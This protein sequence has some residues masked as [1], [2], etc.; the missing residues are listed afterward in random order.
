METKLIF[1]G[2]HSF[3]SKNNNECFVLDFITEPKSTNDKTRAYVVDIAIFT[4]KEKYIDFINKN[5]LLTLCPVHCEICGD[6]AKYS[7]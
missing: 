2:Y 3:T 5:K 4:T 6:K 1:T 7:I